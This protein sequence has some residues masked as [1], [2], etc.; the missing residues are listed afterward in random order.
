MEEDAHDVA[1]DAGS[2]R[3]GPSREV[4]PVAARILEIDDEI[5]AL[6]QRD[7]RSFTSAASAVLLCLMELVIA[8]SMVDRDYAWLVALTFLS[9]A[10]ATVARRLVGRRHRRLLLEQELDSLAGG[11]LTPM[12]PPER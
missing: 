12:K 10:V 3:R 7:F 2:H 8:F 11:A 5:A 4:S 6:E 9:L 1:E